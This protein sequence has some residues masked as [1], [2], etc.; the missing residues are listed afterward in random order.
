MRTMLA[1]RLPMRETPTGAIAWGTRQGD[2]FGG[3][4]GDGAAQSAWKKS[5]AGIGRRAYSSEAG[6]PNAV[7]TRFVIMPCKSGS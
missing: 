7:C 1:R 5:T 2:R 3:P 6:S 4:F